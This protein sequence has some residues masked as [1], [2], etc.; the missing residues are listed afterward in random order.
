MTRNVV[1]AMLTTVLTAC[2]SGNDRGA[3]SAASQA[4]A[5]RLVGAW[6]GTKTFYYSTGEWAGSSPDWEFAIEQGSGSQLQVVNGPTLDLSADSFTVGSLTY[7]P[8]YPPGPPGHCEPVTRV[9]L[10]GAGSID[11]AGMLTVHV[12]EEDTC[13]ATSSTITLEFQMTKVAG[14]STVSRF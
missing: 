11:G 6:K 10:G 12:S 9:I 2:S 3:D 5:S 8:Y 14:L 7:P 4:A 1:Y 13:G